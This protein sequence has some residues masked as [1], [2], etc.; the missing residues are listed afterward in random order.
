MNEGQF[1]AIVFV[2]AIGA[3]GPSVAFSPGINAGAVVAPELVLRANWNV[4]KNGSSIVRT[5]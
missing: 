1:T 5:A 4:I 3:V 2:G